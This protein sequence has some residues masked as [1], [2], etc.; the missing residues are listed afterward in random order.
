MANDDCLPQLFHATNNY[1]LRSMCFV[2]PYNDSNKDEQLVVYNMYLS[3][4]QSVK[5]T[6][7]LTT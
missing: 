3:Y 7:V 2:Y 1:L 4:P 6:I 5:H